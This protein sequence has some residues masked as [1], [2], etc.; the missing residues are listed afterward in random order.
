MA[1]L[2]FYKVA[3]DEDSVGYDEYDAFIVAAHSEYNARYIVALKD[4]T[5][6][7]SVWLNK[8]SATVTELSEYKE[9][10]IILGSFNA[11]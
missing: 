6:P 5:V 7:D 1:E 10:G 9:P 3:R 8:E 2:K 4:K 11:G